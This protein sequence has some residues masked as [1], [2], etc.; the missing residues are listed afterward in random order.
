[1][2]YKTIKII[3]PKHFACHKIFICIEKTVSVLYTFIEKEGGSRGRLSVGEKRMQMNGERI[4]KVLKKMEEQG[5]YQLLVTDPASVS[6]LTGHYEE[7][8][9]RFWALYLNTNGQ[10][11]LVS[12]KL[13]SL[14]EVS[15]VDILWYAD[16]E[17]GI[18]ML[19]PYMEH[20]K[21]LGVDGV[22]MAKFLLEMM[23]RKAASDYT[24]ASEVM[25]QVRACKDSY[26]QKKMEEASAIN[27]KAMEC[28]RGLI[29]E[30]KT[31]QEIAEQML[32]IYRELGADDYSFAPLV[33]FGGNAACGH[34]G[35]DRTVL[36]K[37]D[38]VL[39]DVGCKKDGFCSDMTRTFFFGESDEESRRVY[40]TVLKAQLAAEAAVKPG[41]PL[42][43]IDRTA[44][45]I[46]TEAGYGPY[47]T[48][49]LGHF[50]GYDVH[51]AGDVSST[52]DIVAKPGMIF[53]IEP[54][55]YLPDKVGV[56]IEDL[57]MVTEDGVKLLNHYPKELTVV[58]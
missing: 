36:K 8:W 25:K 2:I 11:K 52:S 34:H 37:G 50:I 48:H 38:C 57:V 41:V 30:G 53:S 58:E 5:I 23:E 33:G 46:I 3:A 17:S 4:E 31:E 15:G 6:Y 35:P 22:T 27:D 56:R 29:K 10:H 12:N 54:G 45:D 18:G 1:M 43:E 55:I 32:G 20:E 19:Y 14:P 26:E 42:S 13:F 44:R 49:R 51:E 16:G 40:N 7:P 47:F 39:F 28:F 21:P 24:D 9:E